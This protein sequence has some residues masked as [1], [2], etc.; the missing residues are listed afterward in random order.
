M[1]D[2]QILSALAPVIILLSLGIVTAIGSRVA[3][4]SPIVG[5][6]VLG[7]ILRATGESTIL[8]QSAVQ[9]L[10]ELGVVFLLFEI[11]LHFSLRH[12]KEQASDI[13]AFGP[14]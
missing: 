8:P 6:I 13:F 2:S 7:L 11:G 5:Y 1:N 4:L 10:A 14:L 9:L 12:I 3:G